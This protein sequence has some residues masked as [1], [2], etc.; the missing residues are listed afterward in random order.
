M[1]IAVTKLEEKSEGISELFLRY[2]HEAIIVSTM[3]SAEPSDPR[4]LFELCN[5]IS[6]DKID[7]LIFTSSLGV[8]RLFKIILPRKNVRIV[9]VG[10]KTARKVKDSGMKSEVIEKFS[11][12]SFA[13]YLGDVKGKTIG[14]AR[15]EVPNPELTGSLISKGAIIIDAPAYRLESTGKNIVDVLN[16]VEAVIFT[17]AK[18][19]ELSGFKPEHARNLKV[20]AIGQKTADTLRDCGLSLYGV[21]KG[22]LE[23]CLVLV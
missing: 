23:S 14:I 11:S 8:E 5:L 1:K 2:G 9:S 6:N 13:G 16:D 12:D 17:S 21:G 7:I 20:L 3:R 10:P 22:T 19:F 4:P 18:S 15:A